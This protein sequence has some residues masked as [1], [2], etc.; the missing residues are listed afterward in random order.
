MSTPTFEEYTQRRVDLLRKLCRILPIP[1]PRVDNWCNT[2]LMGL[3]QVGWCELTKAKMEELTGPISW[4]EYDTMYPW[5]VMACIESFVSKED[6]QQRTDDGPKEFF[7]RRATQQVLTVCN[8]LGI[9]KEENKIVDD[10]IRLQTNLGLLRHIK[11]VD[12]QN[13]S[14]EG[15][16]NG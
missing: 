16:S 10:A 7:E 6:M 5:F 11:Y 14:S 9:R 3:S 1:E 4:S 12:T 8:V 15:G 13:T 2:I